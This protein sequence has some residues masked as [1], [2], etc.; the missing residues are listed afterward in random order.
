MRRRMPAPTGATAEV[1][2]ELEHPRYTGNED[3]LFA[4]FQVVVEF[5]I[6]P[7][8]ASVGWRGGADEIQS[9]TIDEPF[10]FMGRQYQEGQPLPDELLQY[11]K[12]TKGYRDVN[13]YLLSRAEENAPEDDGPDED[14]DPYD[15]DEGR[16]WGGRDY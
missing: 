14:Y 2:L 5:S 4:E 12:P 10:N 13:D 16:E 1:G 3:D 8:D 15:R 9:V 6:S 11:W 7:D